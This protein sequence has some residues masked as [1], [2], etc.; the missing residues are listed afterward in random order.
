MSLKETATRYDEG[1]KEENELLEKFE[2]YRTACGSMHV[3]GVSH[4]HIGT[5]ACTGAT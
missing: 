4:E 5:K 2:I 1:G 3:E